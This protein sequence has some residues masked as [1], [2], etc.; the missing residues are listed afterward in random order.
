MR[1]PRIVAIDGL[2]VVSA[3]ALLAFAPLARFAANAQPQRPADIVRL[4]PLPLHPRGG[5]LQDLPVGLPK[6]L[7]IKTPDDLSTIAEQALGRAGAQ[8][9][10]ALLGSGISKVID[11][12]KWNK[13]NIIYPYQYPVLDRILAG[14]PASGWG[15][16]ATALG[17]GLIELASRSEGQGNSGARYPDAAGTAFAVLDRARSGD[18]CAPQLDLL[19]LVASED[20]PDDK[21]VRTEAA[22][23]VTDC[24]S[25]PTPGWV[26]G[27]YLSQ[28]ENPPLPGSAQS[29]QAE[30]TFSELERDYPASA[31]AITGAADA[32]LRSGVWLADSE[33]FTAR[34]DFRAAEQGYERATAL[35]TRKDSAA[36]LAR[37]LIG[38]GE[39]AQAEKILR[40]LLAASRTPGALLELLIVADENAHNFADAESAARHLEQL[41]QNAYPD[42]PALF[43]APGRTFSLVQPRVPEPTAPLSLGAD[44][45]APLTANLYNAGLGAGGSVEDLS[46]IP[47]Y[48]DVPSVTG[49]DPSC[50]DWEWRRDAVLA[51]HASDALHDFPTGADDTITRNRQCT[52]AY[53]YTDPGA[54]FHPVVQV[55]AGIKAPMGH[56][57]AAQLADNRQNLWRW[58]GDLPKAEAV[59][60]AWMAASPA[61][62]APELRLGEVKYMQKRYDEAA[63]DFGKA[64]R[65]TRNADYRNNLGID[66]ALLDRAASL[67]AASRAAEATPILRDIEN[68]AATGVAYHRNG[69]DETVLHRFAAVAYYARAQ[70]ADHERES[71]ALYAAAEDYAAAQEVLPLLA[72]TI[73]IGVRPEALYDDSTLAELALGRLGNARA[74][75][76]KALAIDPANPAFLMTAGY[77]ADLSRQTHTA[78][79]YDSATLESDSGA[80]PAANDLGVELAR[81]HHNVAAASAL[82]KAVGARPDYALGWFNLGVLYAHMGPLH[83]LASQGALGRAFA[84]DPT[85][86]ERERRLTIDANVYRTALDLSKPLPPRWSFAQAQRRSPTASV[87][88]LAAALLAFGIARARGRSANDFADRWL[89]PIAQSLERIPVIKRLRRPVWA[90]GATVAAFVLPLVHQPSSGVTAAIAYG[91]GVLLIAVVGI[92]ARIVV[93]RA[94]D[95]TTRQQSWGPGVL[96]GLVMGTVGMPW[97]PLPVLSVPGES[98]RTPWTPPPVLQ[99]LAK[100]RRMH[101]AAPMAL[102]LLGALLF[103]E[104]AWLKVPLIE[105]LGIAALIMAA[106]TLLPVSPLDGAKVGTGGLV[107]GAGVVAATILIGLG[108]V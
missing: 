56:N 13:E 53:G 35:G 83:L 87:G 76:R 10:V 1:H 65:L 26:L 96:F 28:R 47:T 102:S 80:Y 91:I 43:P 74:A 34:N 70:L 99:A 45:L 73:G 17:A 97:A 31:A 89:E 81:E 33:P 106:S 4:M 52:N 3:L 25:D 104:S 64:A 69:L 59:I 61:D 40:P 72:D 75:V 9:L 11:S 16:K 58:A 41:N 7:T 30:A 54:P 51:G 84:L 101:L 66:E 12:A 29:G 107:A 92:R 36:G 14:A 38:L 98:R 88:L 32:Q 108:I 94:A 68:D 105:S 57:A 71:G 27:Q 21:I 103:I 55:E 85:L 82:R 19:F 18:E 100:S 46:F 37:A 49:S 67:L 48:R 23:A 44:R 93:A 22:R 15:T 77:V 8:A 42:G 86:R 60:Q 50:A 5:S 39:P 6:G 95:V 90:L 78:V 2:M 79:R 20:P 63:A 24:P 62:P